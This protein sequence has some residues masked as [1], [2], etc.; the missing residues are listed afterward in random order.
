MAQ[1]E[2]YFKDQTLC[3]LDNLVMKPFQRE[4]LKP[5]FTVWAKH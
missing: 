2:N 1:Q 3:Y 5:K 4:V